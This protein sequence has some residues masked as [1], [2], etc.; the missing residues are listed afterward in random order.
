MR[1]ESLDLTAGGACV[2]DNQTGWVWNVFTDI[3]DAEEFRRVCE[4]ATAGDLARL[5]RNPYWRPGD[6]D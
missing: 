1:F 2:L 6:G 5:R 3:D 4:R